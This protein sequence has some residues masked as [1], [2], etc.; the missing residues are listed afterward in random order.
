MQGGKS[1]PILPSFGYLSNG[2]DCA[3]GFNL[4]CPNSLPFPFCCD[5]ERPAGYVEI[6]SH[7]ISFS[8]CAALTPRL[9]ES[10]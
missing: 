10:E 3:S 8:A 2:Q 7:L 4:H 1:P 9:N 5:S 6:L